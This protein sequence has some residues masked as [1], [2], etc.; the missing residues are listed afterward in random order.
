MS[1]VQDAVSEIEAALIRRLNLQ[2]PRFALESA[3]AKVSGSIISPSFR[4]LADSE[5]QR[6]IWDALQAEYG[7]QAARRA[8]TFLAFTPEEWDLG[9]EAEG[10]EQ[11]AGG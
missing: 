9:E 11:P 7:A 4:G 8:G 6:R 1:N 3:G 10:P 5:R 2:S